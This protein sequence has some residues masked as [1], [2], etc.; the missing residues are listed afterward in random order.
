MRP[1][2]SKEVKPVP[3][4]GSFIKLKQTRHYKGLFFLVS[5]WPF[6]PYINQDKTAPRFYCQVAA[7]VQDMLSEFYLMKSH[8]YAINLATTEAR[9]KISTDLESL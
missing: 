3:S 4:H 9:E 1:R 2:P 6:N 8:K 7:Q 5:Y